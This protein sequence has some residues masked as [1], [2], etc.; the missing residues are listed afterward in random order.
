MRAGNW[1]PLDRRLV[2][3]LPKDRPFTE[4]EA[5]FSVSL[6][7]DGGNEVTV[8][9]YAA[10]WGW[11]P[12]KVRRWFHAVGAGII[13]STSTKD[14]RNQR[15]HI[16]IYKPNIPRINNG[17]INLID[18]R[19]LADDVDI[20]QPYSEQK[21]DITQVTTKDPEP[22][23][24]KTPINLPR[25]EG[26]VSEKELLE[27]FEAVWERFPNKEGKEEAR[28][29]YLASVETLDEMGDVEHALDNYIDQ[30]SDGPQPPGW[31]KPGSWWFDHWQSWHE[32]Y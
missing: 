5:A 32:E 23:P 15:G 14:L 12:G 3:F 26:G 2:C 10:Q 6:D 29:C 24:E 13:R 30:Y 7:Y 20:K 1:T 21:T 4:L 22:K 11:S 31:G 16:V 17:H 19:W 8:L 9:G 28:I 25:P 18:S 27:H